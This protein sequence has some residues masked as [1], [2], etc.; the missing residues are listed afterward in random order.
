[1]IQVGDMVQIIRDVYLDMSAGDVTVYDLLSVQAAPPRYGTVTK[2]KRGR[3]YVVCELTRPVMVERVIYG[4]LVTFEA[5]RGEGW[6]LY[7]EDVHLSDVAPVGQ[8]NDP[9]RYERRLL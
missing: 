1:M 4:E 3:V 6:L 5:T 9:A 8:D 7:D 2:I